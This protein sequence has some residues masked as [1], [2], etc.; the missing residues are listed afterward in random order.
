MMKEIKRQ[1]LLE[2]FEEEAKRIGLRKEEIEKAL[3]EAK[4]RFEEL[5]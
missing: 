5:D 4:Q 1:I 2:D 3:K